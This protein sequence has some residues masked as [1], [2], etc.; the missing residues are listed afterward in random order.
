MEARGVLTF[1]ELTIAVQCRN[2]NGRP[3]QPIAGGRRRDE[4]GDT[5]L[6]VVHATTPVVHAP[7]SPPPQ[8]M[9]RIIGRCFLGF[10][11]TRGRRVR[12]AVIGNAVRSTAHH[13]R[14]MSSGHAVG[15]FGEERYEAEENSGEGVPNGEQ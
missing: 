6:I 10:E 4:R 1:L 2:M 3:A 15:Q 9:E 8:V 5:R 13:V 11:W 7:P 12:C 14:L